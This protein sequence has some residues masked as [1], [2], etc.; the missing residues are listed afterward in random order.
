MLKLQSVSKTFGKG[1]VNE[2]KALGNITLDVKKGDFISIIGSNGAGK[3]TLLNAIS[4]VFGVDT[5]SIILDG[6]DIT[7]M[8]EHKR[9]TVIGRLFQH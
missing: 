6:T 4:G 8:S 9:A 5:G 1:T 3:S 7:R 2:K